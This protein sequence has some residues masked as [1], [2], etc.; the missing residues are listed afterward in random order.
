ML[1]RLL[2]ESRP[3]YIPNTETQYITFPFHIF[4]EAVGSFSTVIGSIVT[5]H[6]IVSV[7]LR[8]LVYSIF[9]FQRQYKVISKD[10]KYIASKMS[11]YCQ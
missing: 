10:K 6:K 3:T 7:I 9:I 8:K 11:P 1:C 5:G 2:G 4:K